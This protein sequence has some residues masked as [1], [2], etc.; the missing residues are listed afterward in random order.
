MPERSIAEREMPLSVENLRRCA[1]CIEANA[2]DMIGHLEFITS[3]KIEICLMPD[4]T[5]T[6]K[7]IREAIPEQ[8]FAEYT[9][10]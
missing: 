2:E 9:A 5:P 4:S 6:I 7:V 3:V 8:L 10:D 1:K